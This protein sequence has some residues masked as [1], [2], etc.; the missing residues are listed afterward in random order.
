MA[1]LGL[2]GGLGE[3]INSAINSY[4][5]ERTYKDQ[6]KDVADKLALQQL[7]ERGKLMGQGIQQGEGGQLNYDPLHQAQNDYSLQR[8]QPESQVSQRAGLVNRGS[9]NAISPELGEMIPQGGSAQEMEDYSKKGLLD[10]ALKHKT[11]LEEA[12][13]RANAMGNGRQTRMDLQ[14]D[15]IDNAKHM[16]TLN[17][18]RGDTNLKG[19]MQQYN[20]LSN[21]LNNFLA[22]PNKTPQAIDEMQQ[23]VRANLGIK[24][25][26]GVGERERDYFNS[27]GLNGA[28]IGQFLTGKPAN[29]ENNAFANH[30]VDL[31]KAEMENIKKQRENRLS[32]VTAGNESMYKR[33]GD[34]Y[35]DL[36]SATEANTMA[37]PSVQQNA[38]PTPEQAA[39]ELARRRAGK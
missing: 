18:I 26:S 21:A 17:A 33:R 29:M 23:T 38:M 8:L 10:E 30:M 2:I 15:R 24:G 12:E 35:Q 22:M 39:A 36:M 20:N 28:R 9:V 13:M 3:G 19:T 32:Q 31:A 34:L 16:R 5:T 11:G 27:L 14:T 1:D 7:Q 37:G 25:G 6:R 4:R